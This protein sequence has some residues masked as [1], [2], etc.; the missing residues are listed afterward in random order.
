MY[1]LGSKSKY[2]Y[3]KSGDRKEK[4]FFLNEFSVFQ[5]KKLRLQ[6][7]NF[8]ARARKINYKKHIVFV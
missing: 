1:E 6:I 5:K 8:L 7:V 2:I 4:K 3:I